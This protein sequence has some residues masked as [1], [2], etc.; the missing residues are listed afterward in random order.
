MLE[1]RR[2][3]VTGQNAFGKSIV[4]IDGPPARIFGD[5]SAGLAAIWN[6]GSEPV[7]TMDAADWADIDVVLSTVAN[8]SRFRFFGIA[9]GDPSVSGTQRAARIARRFAAMGRRVN[10]STPTGIRRCIRRKPWT[11]SSCSLVK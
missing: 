10:A 11:T 5:D 8:G 6:T 3:V 7:N 1:V 2:R 9:P 4:V